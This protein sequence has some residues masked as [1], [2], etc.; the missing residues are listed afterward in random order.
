MITAFTVSNL[1]HDRD[2]S[3]DIF[4]EHYD[5]SVCKSFACVEDKIKEVDIIKMV[6]INMVR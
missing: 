2:I 5:V 4:G 3:V 6:Q 1:F